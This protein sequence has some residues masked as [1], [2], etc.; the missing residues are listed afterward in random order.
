M[1]VLE[2][3]I[4][5]TKRKEIKDYDDLIAILQYVKAHKE[6]DKKRYVCV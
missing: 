6:I 3:L 1:N 4:S 5:Q 2:E